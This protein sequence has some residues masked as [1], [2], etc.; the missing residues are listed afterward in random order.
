MEVKAVEVV[1]QIV[2]LCKSK[3]ENRFDFYITG[4]YARNES[5]FKDYDIAIYDNKN[6]KHNWED[7][8]YLFYNQFEDD[9]KP[10]DAQID[11]MTNV[12]RRMNG[13]ILYDNRNELVKRYVYSTENLKDDEYIKYNNVY[14]NLWEKEIILVKHK[15][16]YMGLDKIKRIYKEL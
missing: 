1:N 4:S 12:I 6:E 2:Y 16:Q 11:Q 14:G 13:D 7:I 15:H 10:I 8:L 9:G 3:Y 5:N